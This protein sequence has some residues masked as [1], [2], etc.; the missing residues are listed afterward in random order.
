[1]VSRMHN[2]GDVYCATPPALGDEGVSTPDPAARNSVL[3]AA[4]ERLFARTIEFGGRL[5]PDRVE[6]DSFII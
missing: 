5:K 1:M 4:E 2:Q 6:R 3:P